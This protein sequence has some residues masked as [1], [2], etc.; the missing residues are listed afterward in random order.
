M[1]ESKTEQ[2]TADVIVQLEEKARKKR[3]ETLKAS[4]PNLSVVNEQEQIA[5]HNRFTLV[6]IKDV[7]RAE[8]TQVINENLALLRDKHYL[9]KQ[10]QAF[11]F[12]LMPSVEMHSNALV[13]HEVVNGQRRSTGKFLTVKE[14]AELTGMVRQ[15]ASELITSLI[16]KGIMYEVAD[17]E[18]IKTYG[19]V[20][21]ERV[22]FLN[23]EIIFSGSKNH[24]NA[25]ICRMV[26][27]ADRIERAGLHLPW[28]IWIKDGAEY[29][30]LYKR[31][32]Y[33][34]LKAGN[35]TNA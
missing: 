24:I 23:P 21:S 27:G 17:T 32:T 1:D 16:Q 20:I 10:E 12:A 22:L 13:K 33:L 11:L 34:R 15:T 26:T 9:T 6:K 31:D 5:N 28:K 14:I 4:K 29:G 30:R 2:T 19:R 18:Q 8:F 7:N 3:L 35:S 25:T